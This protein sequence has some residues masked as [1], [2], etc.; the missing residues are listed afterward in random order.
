MMTDVN[1][2]NMRTVSTWRNIFYLV[3]QNKF[4]KYVLTYFVVIVIIAFSTIFL[5]KLVYI[6]LCDK[7]LFYV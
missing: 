2:Q 7:S 5:K 6:Y 4:E 1:I 3:L